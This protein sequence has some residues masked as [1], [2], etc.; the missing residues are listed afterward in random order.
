M[1]TTGLTAD[2]LDREL[3]RVLWDV[4]RGELDGD[5]ALELLDDYRDRVAREVEGR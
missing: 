5:E 4:E 2:E 3:D 1:A